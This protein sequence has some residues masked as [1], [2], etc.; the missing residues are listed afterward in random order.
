MCIFYCKIFIEF[1]IFL[2]F[3]NLYMVVYFSFFFCNEVDN[4][5]S[6]NDESRN[7]KIDLDL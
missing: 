3:Y 4:F 2:M 5:D 7:K 1:G 6:K